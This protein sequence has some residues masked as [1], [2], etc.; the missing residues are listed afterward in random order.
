MP[1]SSEANRQPEVSPNTA[2]GNPFSRRALFSYLTI[3]AFSS[4]YSAFDTK[5]DQSCY[6]PGSRSRRSSRMS[7]GRL[8][9]CAASDPLMR[10]NTGVLLGLAAGSL[11][12]KSTSEK[13]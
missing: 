3:G 2:I 10:I 12:I 11:L 6:T 1:Y 13:P 9:T 5:P 7:L 4:F 8:L